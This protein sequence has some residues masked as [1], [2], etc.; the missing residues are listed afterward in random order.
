[1][2]FVLR[3]FKRTGS[4]INCTSVK[5]SFDCDILKYPFRS[6]RSEF[7]NVQCL[8]ASTGSGITSRFP[9]RM[10]SL[11]KR[12]VRWPQ[13]PLSQ[14]VTFWH[15]TATFPTFPVQKRVLQ[16]PISYMLVFPLCTEHI[17]LVTKTRLVQRICCSF[18]YSTIS[19]LH[20]LYSFGFH[21]ILTF[22]IFSSL[23]KYFLNDNQNNQILHDFLF[24]LYMSSRRL[25][26]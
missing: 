14:P 23:F 22:A 18:V 2:S 12:C 15:D 13:L 1:M 26:Y 17:S 10:V 25:C 8:L 3:M 21:D 16:E 11:T 9:R 19:M 5:W 24:N 4:H 6:Y 20:F 7:Q